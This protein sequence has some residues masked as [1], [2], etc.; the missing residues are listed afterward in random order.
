[1]SNV[2]PNERLHKHPL[3]SL[4]KL[5]GY[6]INS[7]HQYGDRGERLVLGFNDHKNEWVVWF[8]NDKGEP[9]DGFYTKDGVE[10]KWR[11]VKRIAER[12]GVK[13]P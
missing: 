7:Y 1:M 12:M 6:W 13:L 4:G 5:Q 11:Y 8:V 9:R 3:E 10:A 2:G